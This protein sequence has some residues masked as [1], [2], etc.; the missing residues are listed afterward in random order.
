[1]CLKILLNSH[2]VLNKPYGFRYL[3]EDELKKRK[4]NFT[5]QEDRQITIISWNTAGK[6]PK[7][8]DNFE[9]TD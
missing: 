5:K 1:M 9:W 7:K 8:C 3:V 4:A 2:P 6:S